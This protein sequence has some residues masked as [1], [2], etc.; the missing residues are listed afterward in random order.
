[1]TIGNEDR[2]GNCS[3]KTTRTTVESDER[4]VSAARPRSVTAGRRRL[5]AV[6]ACRRSDLAVARVFRRGHGLLEARSVLAQA[7]RFRVSSEHLSRQFD[8]ELAG[9]ADRAG[10]GAAGRSRLLVLDRATGARPH[11]STCARSARS[12]SRRGSPR[13][14]QHTRL[15]RAAARP[16]RAERRRRGMSA[17]GQRRTAPRACRLRQARSDK[18]ASRPNSIWDAL[19]H[20]GQKLKPGALVSDFEGA[21][22]SRAAC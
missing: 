5:A 19:M 4:D 2:L 11:G 18:P 14:Q 22:A 12:F 10:C 21:P 17:A 13:R 9:R 1:M 3:I 16:P 6:S 20:P 8:F 15:R 7:A